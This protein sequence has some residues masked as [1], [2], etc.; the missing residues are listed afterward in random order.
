MD[1]SFI[2][3]RLNRHSTQTEESFWPSFTDI[4]TVIVMIF[5]LA[6][7]ILLIRNMELLRQLRAT[8]EAEQQAVELART[9]GA[10]N[11]TLE[12]KLI[13][14]EHELS[15]LRMQ[16][17]RMEEESEQQEAAIT[18]Q[19]YQID[20]LS[21]DRSNLTDRVNRLALERDKLNS[22]VARLT[23]DS[24]RLRTQVSE[25]NQNIDSLNLA[26]KKLQLLQETTLQDLATLRLSY[27]SQEE[28]LEAA[29]ALTLERNQALVELQTDYDSLEIKYNKLIRP[30]RSARGKTV[31]EVRYYKSKGNFRIDYKGPGNRDF[32]GISRTKLDQYLTNLQK[33]HPDGL[34]IKVILPKDSGL[35]YSEAWSFTNHLHQTYDY[36]YQDEAKKQRIIS[37]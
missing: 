26:L 30:A 28:E 22:Q 2:D 29:K 20:S 11:E 24:N 13:A 7:V 6:M 15:M 3:L 25:A 32:K 23:D 1:D 35:S 10:E 17:M 19:R 14:R 36:Y 34:Y 31:V 4:M 5:L 33:Q 37:D 16:L 18:S 12:E 9:T 8:M 27:R 21:R